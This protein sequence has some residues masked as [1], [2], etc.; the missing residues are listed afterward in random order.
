M[1]MLI[2]PTKVTAAETPWNSVRACPGI[3]ASR[4]EVKGLNIPSSGARLRGMNPA[5]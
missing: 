1:V 5:S 4:A 3:S 2:I